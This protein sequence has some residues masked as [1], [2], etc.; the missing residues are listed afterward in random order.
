MKRISQI[1]LL[2]LLVVFAGTAMAGPWGKGMGYGMGSFPYASANVTAD[3]AANLQ[4]LRESFLKEITPL[5]SELFAKKSEMRILWASSNPE[6]EKI[7]ALQKDLQVLQGKIQEKR[8]QYNLETRKI[9]N[10]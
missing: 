8:L 2:G 7:T 4:T 10:P 9:L 1:L 5:Q 3:Q 6:P